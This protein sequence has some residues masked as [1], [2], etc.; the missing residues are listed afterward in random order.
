VLTNLVLGDKTVP[1]F[2]QDDC[3]PENLAAGLRPLL[4]DTPQR[5]VQV[6]AFHRLEDLMRIDE[7]S[8][9]A[10]AARIVTEI[11]QVHSSARSS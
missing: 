4:A 10:R 11:L 6:D 7:D 3:T 5:R 1:E 8:P 2:M 9:S